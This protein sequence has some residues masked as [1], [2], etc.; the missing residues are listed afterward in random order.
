[1]VAALD[2][3]NLVKPKAYVV[4]HESATPS[5]KMKRELKAHVKTLL[6]PVRYPR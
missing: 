2:D 6:A 1:M 3:A 5:L 4:L